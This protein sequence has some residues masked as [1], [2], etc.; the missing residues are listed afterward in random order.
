MSPGRPKATD[1]EVFTAAHRVMGRRTPAQL[2]LA[3]I[4]AEAGVTPAALVQRFGSR[5]G[6]LLALIQAGEDYPRHLFAGLRAAHRSPLRAIRAWAACMAPMGESP[7]TLAHHLAYL[8]MDL[9]DPEFFP[10]VS[11]QAQATRRE[12]RTLLAAAKERGELRPDAPVTPLGR[13]VDVVVTGSLMSSAMSPEGSATRQVEEDLRFV[14][15]P[16]L[17]AKGK[18]MGGGSGG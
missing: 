8:Q 5:R 9:S 3:D 18:R 17:T 11:R 6:L 7:A 16:W 14:L 1:A 2:R 13:T 15:G 4:A 12:I 10:P